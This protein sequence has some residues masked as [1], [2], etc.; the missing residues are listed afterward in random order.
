MAFIVSRRHDGLLEGVLSQSLNDLDNLL[1]W[2][3][4]DSLSVITKDNESHSQDATSKNSCAELEDG[5][6]PSAVGLVDSRVGH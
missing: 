1:N 4:H 3:D 6:H 5:L 2:L